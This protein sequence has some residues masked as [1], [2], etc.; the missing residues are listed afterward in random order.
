MSENIVVPVPDIVDDEI[1][2]VHR[3]DEVLGYLNY[4]LWEIEDD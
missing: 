3:L 1:A 2:V 4:I